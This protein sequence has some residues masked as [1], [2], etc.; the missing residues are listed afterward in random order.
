MSEPIKEPCSYCDVPTSDNHQCPDCGAYSHIIHAHEHR[1]N[2]VL[3]GNEGFR[4]SKA[5]QSRDRPPLTGR[6]NANE[7]GICKR[8]GDKNAKDANQKKVGKDR[9]GL[10]R[11]LRFIPTP[12]WLSMTL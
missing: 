6:E 3:V 8:R 2:G 11:R 4:Q 9:S 5:R 10:N 7:M 1:W 12:T